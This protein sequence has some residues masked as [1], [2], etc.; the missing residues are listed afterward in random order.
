M[1]Y[2]TSRRSQKIKAIIIHF[3]STFKPLQKEIKNQFKTF[4]LH[5]QK[6]Y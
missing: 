5:F 6:I 3:I 2:T 4:S 1:K